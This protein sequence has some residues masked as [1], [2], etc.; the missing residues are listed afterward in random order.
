MARYKLRDYFRKSRH[1][2]A[3]PIN[4]ID[5]LFAAESSEKGAARRDLDNLLAQLPQR[6]RVLIEAANCQGCPWTRPAHRLQ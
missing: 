6:Q 3:P 4:S 1:P 2:Q 5:E